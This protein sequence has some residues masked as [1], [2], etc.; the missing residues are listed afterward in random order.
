MVTFWMAPKKYQIWYPAQQKYCFC[1]PG[2]DFMKVIYDNW[3]DTLQMV[4]KIRLTNDCHLQ[5]VYTFLSHTSLSHLHAWA[6]SIVFK[7]VKINRRGNYLLHLAFC[8]F[9]EM[10]HG[11]TWQRTRSHIW[12]SQPSTSL[13]FYQGKLKMLSVMMSALTCVYNWSAS[14]WHSKSIRHPIK[15]GKINFERTGYI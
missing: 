1:V 2:A 5:I 14:F 7:C 3:L 15:Q 9:G 10:G 8:D 4:A 12:H 11:Q 6:A 13:S